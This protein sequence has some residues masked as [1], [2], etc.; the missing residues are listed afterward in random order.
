MDSRAAAMAHRSRP[1][2]IRERVGLAVC[3]RVECRLLRGVLRPPSG[4]LLRDGRSGHRVARVSGSVPTGLDPVSRATTKSESIT[5]GGRLRSSDHPRIVV[6]SWNHSLDAVAIDSNTPCCRQH[7]DA[8]AGRQRLGDC[9]A[10]RCGPPA[11]GR[12]PGQRGRRTSSVE[13]RLDDA[14]RAAILAGRNR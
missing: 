3:R 10:P 7:F 11:R 12:Q 4:D 5:A 14:W 8:A 9:R 6:N 2:Q 13:R 1:F